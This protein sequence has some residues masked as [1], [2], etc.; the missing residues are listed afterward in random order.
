MRAL[1]TVS[2]AIIIVRHDST[3]V[4][5]DS[6][7]FSRLDIIFEWHRARDRRPHVIILFSFDNFMQKKFSFWCGVKLIK[8]LFRL[9]SQLLVGAIVFAS[10]L[11][12]KTTRLHRRL[13]LFY[14]S[15]QWIIIREYKVS[16]TK[17]NS[18]CRICSN[19]H[20][21]ESHITII[22]QIN[23][24]RETLVLTRSRSTRRSTHYRR[25]IW[26]FIHNPC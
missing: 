22:E 15:S 17:Q 12:I 10:K 21:C 2:L 16:F 23:E 18:L 3:G 25:S 11:I 5:F 19:R 24:R 13:Q 9:N 26:V 8:W 4:G 1:R 20:G 14:F 6:L 7:M